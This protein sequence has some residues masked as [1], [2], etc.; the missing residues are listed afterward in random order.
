MPSDHPVSRLNETCR[1]NNLSLTFSKFNHDDGKVSL[2]I[3]NPKTNRFIRLVGQ[4]NSAK[5]ARLDAT[6]IAF[7][8]SALQ[9]LMG[10]DEVASAGNPTIDD[11][12]SITR[13]YSFALN[14]GLPFSV[15]FIKRTASQELVVKIHIGAKQLIGKWFEKFYLYLSPAQ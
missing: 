11:S 12:D 4:G 13:I 14:H 7:Q 5:D 1:N 8:T 9:E 2:T 3:A 15:E 6:Q 10:A